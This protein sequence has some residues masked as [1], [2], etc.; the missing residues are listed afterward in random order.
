[1]KA[2][3]QL[4]PNIIIRPPPIRYSHIALDLPLIYFIYHKNRTLSYKMRSYTSTPL[5]CPLNRYCRTAAFRLSSLEL[6][7]S[8]FHLGPVHQ[9]KPNVSLMSNDR[10]EEARYSHLEQTGLEGLFLFLQRQPAFCVQL[11]EH[12]ASLSVVLQLQRG[13]GKGEGV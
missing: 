9:D 5:R 1:M 6:C 13:E 3:A 11:C 4:D 8:S 7:K 12:V 2:P 10:G